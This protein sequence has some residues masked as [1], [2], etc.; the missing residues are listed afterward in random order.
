MNPEEIQIP[1]LGYTLFA[2]WYVG[3]SK[4]ILLVLIGYPSS[5]KS[6]NDLVSHIVE[7]T[8]VSAL[9][10]EYSG[11]GKSIFKPEEISPAQ[12]FLEV[13]KV[14]DWLTEKY[15][16]AQLSVLGTSYG[17]FLG[18][19]LTKYRE[20]KNLILRVPAIYRP[21]DFYT[22]NKIINNHDVYMY[23]QDAIKLSSHPL[24]V[25]ASNFKGSTLV[26]VH[27]FDEFIPK[28][29]TDK[30]IEIFNADSYLAK[31]F[32]HSF[33]LDAPEVEK[34]AYKNSISDWINKHKE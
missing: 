12:N 18:T 4:D 28:T 10:L 2:D 34:L 1:Y 16:Q 8:G 20:F 25:R 6:A 11:Y 26:V 3:K 30:Y 32:K 29:V 33:K 14:F 23:R 31:G 15:P 19:Q 7:N 27:E 17:A 5:R 13:V 9:V 21:Q 24:F 22:S